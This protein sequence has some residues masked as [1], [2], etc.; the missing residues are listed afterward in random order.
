MAKHFGRRTDLPSEMPDSS[1]AFWAAVRKLPERQSQIVALHYVD[2][3]P[4]AAGTGWKRPAG[5]HSHL[6]PAGTLTVPAGQSR[7]LVWSTK[8]HL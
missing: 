4:V 7:H 1:E 5:Q 2:D 6:M 3:Q 8:W